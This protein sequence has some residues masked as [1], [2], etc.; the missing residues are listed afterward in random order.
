MNLI[1]LN[2]K[3]DA[4]LV[5]WTIRRAPLPAS[6]HIPLRR[7]ASISR[8]CVPVGSKV[9]TGDKIAVPVDYKSVSIH[10]SVSGTVTHIGKHPHP[11]YGEA[12]TLTITADEQ[13]VVS[14]DF[15]VERVDWKEMSGERILALLPEN[16]LVD[17]TPEMEPLHHKLE[18]ECLEETTLVFNA[19]EPEPYL[20]ADQILMMSH[21]VEILRGAEMVRKASG[22]QRMLF[23]V[24]KNQ[25]QAAELLRSKIYLHKWDHCEVKI[26]SRDYPQHHPEVLKKTLKQKDSKPAGGYCILNMSTAYSVYE[27]IALQRPLIERIVTMGGECIVDS[28]NLKIRIGSTMAASLKACRGL[29]REPRKMLMGGPL[30][31]VCQ[32]DMD[33]P[34]LTGTQAILA[35]P[36]EVAKPVEVQACIRCGDCVDACP[37]NISPVMIT[38]AAERDLFESAKLYGLDSCI[39]CGNCSYVCPSKRPMVELIRY[40]ATHVEAGEPHSEDSKISFSHQKELAGL[41]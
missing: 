9:L 6:V 33:A 26:L 16:G 19:C 39:E 37:V 30:Q 24:D 36:K 40:A 18:T 12:Q 22:A 32:N 8:P 5:E 29:L 35:L 15:G 4:S 27:A 21:V 3:K 34:V 7:G 17:L 13:E 25:E 11:Y 14:A 1:S 2:G 10:A 31:G 28:K 38:L 41:S 23:V 20:T